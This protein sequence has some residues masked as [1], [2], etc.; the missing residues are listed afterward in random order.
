MRTWRS[1]DA[2]ERPDVPTPP[3]RMPPLLGGRPLKRWRY[4]GF[5]GAELMGCVA[6]A[7]VGV[8][9]VAWWA[10]WDRQARTLAEASHRRFGPVELT[11][12][13][14]AFE[15]GP[16]A[17][18]LGFV[19][20]GEPVETISP[21]GERH[22]WTRKTP[23]HLRGRVTLAGRTLEVDCRGL[24]DDS[25][26]Y[27]ARHTVWTW[28]A[29][30]GTGPGGEAVTWNLVEGVH[31]DP[32]SSERTVWIDG[33]PHH[34]APQTF[35]GLERVGRLRFEAEATRAKRENLLL[36]RSEYEQPFGTFAGE[37]PL[38]GELRDGY[39]VME[40]HDVRW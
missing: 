1:G 40:F 22:I 26:G 31:D 8:A 9:R 4:V 38:A 14:V 25:A 35:D 3:G 37:L 5:Y 29:G 39:G 13:K 17:V 20:A 32:L 18:E 16:A 27:H 6:L 7:R 12:G 11:A 19:P 10:L 15:D 28:S 33:E 30:V 36:I 34:V 2:H 24:L 23:L 21:H